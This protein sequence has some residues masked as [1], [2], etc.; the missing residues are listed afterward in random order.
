MVQAKPTIESKTVKCPFCEE[1]LVDVTYTSEFMSVHTAHAAGKSSRIPNYHEEKYDV[2][3]KCPSCGKGKKEIAATL[4]DG[5]IK[6]KTHEERIARL[7]AAGLP[8]MIVNV[9]KRD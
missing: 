2:H 7:K 8:T 1:G 9:R 3:S 4:R 5:G 6:P